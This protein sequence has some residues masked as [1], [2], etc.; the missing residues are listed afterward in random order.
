MKTRISLRIRTVWSESAWSAFKTAKDIKP[1]HADIENSDQT[2]RMDRPIR[3]L[4]EST[5][6]CYMTTHI[7]YVVHHDDVCQQ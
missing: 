3:V 7:F 4:V 5:L 2:A 6:Q 1:P